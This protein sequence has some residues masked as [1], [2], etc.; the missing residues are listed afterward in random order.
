MTVDVMVDYQWRPKPHANGRT[1]SQK[2]TRRVKPVLQVVAPKIL[3]SGCPLNERGSFPSMEGLNAT[4]NSQLDSLGEAVIFVSEHEDSDAIHKEPM[5]LAM[6]SESAKEVP[7]GMDSRNS[8]MQKAIS[9]DCRVGYLVG[10]EARSTNSVLDAVAHE[11]PCSAHIKSPAIEAT[12]GTNGVQFDEVG[13][14]H[15]FSDEGGE[16]HCHC[17]GPV[18]ALCIQSQPLSGLD[19]LDSSYGNLE[20]DKLEVAQVASQEALC[21]DHLASSQVLGDLDQVADLKHSPKCCPAVTQ[22]LG[23]SDVDDMGSDPVFLATQLLTGD[24]AFQHSLRALA[25]DHKNIV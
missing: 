16:S 15:C 3:S 19:L 24:T 7:E 12:A 9:T 8:D 21:S 4:D 17:K 10:L 20:G 11:D 23:D 25:P 5:E 18:G 1:A 22:S 13:V 14:P 6:P 2:G